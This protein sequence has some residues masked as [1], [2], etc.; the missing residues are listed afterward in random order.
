MADHR[1][2]QTSAVIVLGAPKTPAL[3][4]PS[5]PTPCVSP[6]DS[7]LCEPTSPFSLGEGQPA[8]HREAA[9]ERR[10]SRGLHVL[11]TEA[12]ALADLARLY[13]EDAGARDG[14]DRAVQVI[15]H[16]S[17]AG[18]KLVV[19]GVG[20]SGHIGRKMVATL[21]SLAIRSAFLHP[22]E[23]LHGDLGIV[24]PRD[25][26][27]FITF[28]G[29]TQELLLL[30]PHL[31][32]T[33]PA[34]VLTSHTR[35][36]TCEIIRRRPDAVLVPAPIPEAEKTSFGV[37]APS[38]STTVALALCDALAM[39][40]ASELHD[41]VPAEFARNHPGG[42][43]G[44]ATAAET[45]MTADKTST[46]TATRRSQ[47]TIK[48]VAVPWDELSRTAGL[49]REDLGVDLLRVG[50]GS[51]TGWVRVDDG[52]AAPAKIRQLSRSDAG[53]RLDEVPGLITTRRDMIPLPSDTSIRQAG[54]M[55]R[56]M[57][58]QNGDMEKE[59]SEEDEEENG[60]GGLCGYDAV[61]AAVEGGSIVGVLEARQI[62]V[63]L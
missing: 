61:I 13:E 47:T 28:S 49:S 8:R 21:Q 63:C 50:Y 17:A 60:G 38:T 43:I 59:E 11:A 16:R 14:F 32:E 9:T 57:R 42:A 53:L 30:L 40:A 58:A 22:T 54:D 7:T 2:I 56:A 55:V 23:A 48:H 3:P 15:A 19:V 24:G 10:L 26:L 37:S 5:P 62:L 52:V 6:H 27:L 31:A 29:K 44:A 34:I 1:P 41:N 20:K 25:T 36:E 4:P 51:K 39:T 18:G 46:P 35:A 45:T 33:L 12:A